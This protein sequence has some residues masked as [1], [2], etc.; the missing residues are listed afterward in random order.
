VTGFTGTRELSNR[1]DDRYPHFIFHGIVDDRAENNLRVRSAEAVISLAARLPQASEIGA[2]GN[3]EEDSSRA[4]A[5]ISK[6]GLE[7]ACLAAST[8]RFSP[9][10]CRCPSRP[11][12]HFA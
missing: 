6:S 10:L 7:I 4:S 8:A 9:K 12:R 3:R 1:S 11:N 2:A 5:E